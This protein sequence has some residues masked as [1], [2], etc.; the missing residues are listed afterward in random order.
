[1]KQVQQYLN[2][3]G[4]NLTVDGVIGQKTIQ[5]LDEFLKSE[6]YNLKYNKVSKGIIYVRTDDKLTNSYDDFAVLIIND[7]IEMVVPC[8]TTAGKFYVQNPI[9]TGG[10]TGTAIACKQQVKGSHQFVTAKTW[11]SLWLNAP[12]FR[13]IKPIAIYRDGNKDG[14]IDT[15]TITKGL[16]GINLHR[17]GL[18]SLIDRW[19]AGCQVVPDKYWFEI[20]KYFANGEVI[21]FT[22]I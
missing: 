16:Y 1:M 2:Q 8:S 18:G 14:I 6:M 11:T 9:T 12:F 20:V 21:D 15:K 5:A 13:Q 10:I 17:G 19:S 22:L 7:K 4:C 3:R